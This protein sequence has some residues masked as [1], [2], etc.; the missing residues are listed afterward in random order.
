[1]TDS[2]TKPRT[3]GS[4]VRGVDDVARA[5]DFWTAALDYFP[6]HE[7]D[8]TWVILVPREGAGAQLALALS[9]SGRT[10]TPS[11]RSASIVSRSR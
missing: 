6:R 4:T 3:I 7:P 11:P 5:K 8:D 9:W 10:L 1:M 2:S